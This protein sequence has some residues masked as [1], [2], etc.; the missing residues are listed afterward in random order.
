MRHEQRIASLMRWAEALLHHAADD[1]E[2]GHYSDD[3][4]AHL[5]DGLDRL[6]LAMRGTDHGTEG[7]SVA[8]CE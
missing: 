8:R 4:L 2:A 7:N 5:A 3:E 1:I 6:T